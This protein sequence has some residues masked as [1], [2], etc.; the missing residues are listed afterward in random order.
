MK[1]SKCEAIIPEG[2][3]K[4][5]PGTKECVQCSSEEQN[6]VRTVITGKTTYSEIEV[7]KNKNTKEY[8][9]RLEGK[10]RTGF[11]SMLYR[12][13]RNEPSASKV[14]LKS[15]IRQIPKFTQEHFERVLKET[16]NWIDHDKDYGL[17]IAKKAL[18]NET[19]SG[20]QY[21]QIIQIVEVMKPT[22]VEK[23]KQIK[24]E[25]VDEEILHVFRNWKY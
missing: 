10:G 7:I 15:N 8:L 12:G 4:I 5:L 21:R 13:S 25:S 23:K 6:M 1:C 19:I 20:P 17:D 2:R 9:K 24:Q 22:P 11:G 16:L 14:S 3:L 18:K